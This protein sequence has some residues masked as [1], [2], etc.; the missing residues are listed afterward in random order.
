MPKEPSADALELA[1]LRAEEKELK[2]RL[3]SMDAKHADDQQRIRELEA[4]LADAEHFV[5]LRPKLQ[6]VP[7]VFPRRVI[8]AHI[9]P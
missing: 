1:A 6:G 4:R 9:A 2:T 3:R 7:I 5:A 8:H